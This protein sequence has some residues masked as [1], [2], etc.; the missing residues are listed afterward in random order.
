MNSFMIL[1][2][3][4]RFT[5]GALRLE[6]E[7]EVL[8]GETT[9]LNCTTDKDSFLKVP[10]TFKRGSGSTVFTCPSYDTCLT[11]F[12]GYVYNKTLS[13]PRKI[14]V[15]ITSVTKK[16][17][18][19]TCQYE[20]ENGPIAQKNITV[21]DPA[22]GTTMGRALRLE[23]ETEVLLGETTLLNCTT[24]KDSFLKVPITFKRGSGSTVF[25][26]PSYDTCLT[27]FQGYVYNKTLSTPRKIVVGITSVTKKDSSWTCQYE[28]ENGPI[29]QKNITVSD[30]ASGTTM[31][32][33]GSYSIQ[34]GS[35]HLVAALWYYFA[36]SA[37]R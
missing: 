19:W 27:N 14:V 23:T 26:C 31:G 21:S 33:S 17:S 4:L 15:G 37:F 1:V 9:L 12:Q 6:T 28:M 32:L 13:T 11:N 5:G 24:D 34:A 2:L 7:T 3:M 20:M 22:S 8:L 30:P 35:P 10:I 25:T 16:D 29:A 36:F 18:S